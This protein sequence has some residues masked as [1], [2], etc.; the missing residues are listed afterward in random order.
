MKTAFRTANPALSAK[1]FGGFVGVRPDTAEAMTIQG[2]V[3]KTAILLAVLMVAALWPWKMF[4]GSPD[5][6]VILPWLLVGAGA[7]F[8]LALVTIFKK[9]WAPYLSPL[10][11]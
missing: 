10:Y 8:V 5:P 3:N 2:T 4:F 6:T 9:S 11:A 1:S 7:G